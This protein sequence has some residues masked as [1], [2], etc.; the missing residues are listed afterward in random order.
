MLPKKRLQ[1]RLLTV[2]LGRPWQS[3]LEESLQARLHPAPASP[4]P[5]PLPPMP[6]DR[7][8]TQ[9]QTSPQEWGKA[10]HGG[11]EAA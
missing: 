2:A 7:C 4:P 11:L 10:L 3:S 8:L 6:W 9:V 5:P 1:Q